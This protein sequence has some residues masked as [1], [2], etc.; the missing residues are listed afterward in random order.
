M[1]IFK[2]LNDLPLPAADSNKVGKTVLSS[3]LD[4][5]VAVRTEYPNGKSNPVMIG[6]PRARSTQRRPRSRTRSK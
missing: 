5:G 6:N 3:G 4:P 1:S 2:G